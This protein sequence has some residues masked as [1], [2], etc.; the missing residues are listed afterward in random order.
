MADVWV[1]EETRAVDLKD[2]RTHARLREVL[3]QLGQRPTAS[4]PAA[5]GGHADM[6]AAYRLFDNPKVTFERILIPH[7]QST[8]ERMAAQP[9]VLLVQDTTEIDLT[10]PAQQVRGAGPLD[11][12]TRQGLFLHPLHAFTPEGTPLG[13]VQATPW[14][15]E[16]GPSCAQLTRAQ[17]AAI[18]IEE[19]ESHRWLQTLRRAQQEAKHCPHTRLISVC[20]SEADIYEVLAEPSRID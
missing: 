19:K 14:V 15:R 4:I 10:R 5:C 16:P 9:T 2:T 1:M 6:T 3:T 18:P 12:D 7:A 8:R 11:G 20:D 13:T 17:R